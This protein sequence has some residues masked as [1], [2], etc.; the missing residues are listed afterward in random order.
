VAKRA[1]VTGGT[2]FIGANL[3]RRLVHDGHDV[4]LLVRPN[5]N[6]ARLLDIQE[7]LRLH[8]ADVSDAAA[9]ASAAHAIR[10]DWIFHLAAHGQYSWE[11]DALTMLRTNVLATAALLGACLEVGFEAFV[12]T[13]SSSEYGFKDH[14]PR[15]DEA[16]EPNSYYSVAKGAATAYCRYAARDRQA[17]IPTLRLYSAYG[18]YE[19]PDRLIPTLIKHGMAGKLPPLVNPS[20]ARDF[21]YVDDVVDA[22]L[23][24]AA[25]PGQELGAIYN[26]GSGVQTTIGQAVDV[27][28]R[29]FDLRVEPQWG[30]MPNRV[31]DTACWVADNRA[32]RDALGWQPRH[33]FEA[34]F[35]K[36]AAVFNA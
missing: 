31:W 10:P 34:G 4:H 5:H 11:T 21:V 36:T 27:C 25:M 14:P 18:P 3:V 13:G 1:L 35:R 33:G 29:A 8:I 7:A 6:L 12:N 9:T 26:V 17:H 30:A 15:E 24:A 16:L 20:V 19:H 28:R 22:Y 32:I 2:G 23:L